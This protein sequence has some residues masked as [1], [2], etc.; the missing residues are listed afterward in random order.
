MRIPAAES[1]VSGAAHRVA[2]HARRLVALEVELAKAE[3]RRKL[4][5]TALGIGL[6][7]AAALVGLF[8]IALLIAGATAALALALPVWAAILVTAGAA[9][10]VAG[11]LAAGALLSLRR[12]APPVPEQA[13]E[14][15]RITSET[16]RSNGRR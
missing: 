11:G 12:G 16:L 13:L 8:A 5:A 10:L 6:G 1:G 7:V 9:L 4:A 15:A 3:V 2:D 14:E